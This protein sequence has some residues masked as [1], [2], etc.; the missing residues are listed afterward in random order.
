M[1]KV[2]ARKTEKNSAEDAVGDVDGERIQHKSATY[3]LF[4]RWG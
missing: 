1:I 4:M 2:L 3:K